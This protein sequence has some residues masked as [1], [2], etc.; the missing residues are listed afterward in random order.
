MLSLSYDELRQ[1][2]N[3]CHL[4]DDI[5]KYFFLTVHLYTLIQILLIFFPRA[6]L[7]KINS[8]SGYELKLKLAQHTEAETNGHHFPDNIFNFIF[9][10][11]NVRVAINI[12]PSNGSWCIGI[13]GEMSGTVCVTFTWDI[14]IY[15]SCL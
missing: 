4:A 5:F 11:K 15:M 14:Y 12:S 7:S 10:N 3:G 13:K 2:N 1:E 8:G 9:L 6:Q